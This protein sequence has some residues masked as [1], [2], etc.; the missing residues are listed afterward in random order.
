MVSP[1]PIVRKLQGHSWPALK[2][3][4]QKIHRNTWKKQKSTSDETG[5]CTD[6]CMLKLC[7]GT[8]DAFSTCLFQQLSLMNLPCPDDGDRPIS[9]LELPPSSMAAPLGV[10]KIILFLFSIS[11]LSLKSFILQK[12]GKCCCYMYL[13]HQEHCFHPGFLTCNYT[14]WGLLW[15]SLKKDLRLD[16]IMWLPS[17][18]SCPLQLKQSVFKMQLQPLD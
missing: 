1:F 13:N 18:K 17:L 12:Y 6:F 4:S 14:R 9:V 15:S 8:V 16:L 2:L 10:C 5:V 7:W 11:H 3:L